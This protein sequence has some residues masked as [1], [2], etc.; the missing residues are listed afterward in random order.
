MHLPR[1]V[2][3]ILLG[4]LSLLRR[5]ASAGGAPTVSAWHGRGTH[6]MPSAL[7]HTTS[8]VLLS[9]NSAYLR[10]RAAKPVQS[11]CVYA[12]LCLLAADIRMT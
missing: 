4:G 11:R 7:H 3:S 5:T 10:A 2:R 8:R 9:S 6:L 12:E 1:R